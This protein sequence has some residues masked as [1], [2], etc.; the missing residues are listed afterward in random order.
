MKVSNLPA[1]LASA[2]SVFPTAARERCIAQPADEVQVNEVIECLH[3]HAAGDRHRHA[4]QV[5]ALWS[6]RARAL[7]MAADLM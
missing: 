6:G 1:L 4:E 3:L 7:A 2:G 5:V